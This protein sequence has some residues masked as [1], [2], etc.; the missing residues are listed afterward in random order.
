VV[1]RVAA[2]DFD[3][4]ALHD[5]RDGGAE[6]HDGLSLDAGPV[7]PAPFVTVGTGFLSPV[8]RGRRV[9]AE[10][11]LCVWPLKATVRQTGASGREN[12]LAFRASRTNETRCFNSGLMQLRG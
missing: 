9:R 8:K 11:L 4:L 2:E 10:V 12:Y 5:F 3:A 7:D 6:L 1:D